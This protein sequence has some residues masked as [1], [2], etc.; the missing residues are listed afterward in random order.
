VFL[1]D[2]GCPTGYRPD[3]KPSDPYWLH[4]AGEAKAYSF[5]EKVQQLAQLIVVG[6]VRDILPS[7]WITPDGHRPANPHIIHDLLIITPIRVEV[8][9][10]A[11]G[12]YALPDIYLAAPGG[13]IGDDCASYSGSGPRPSFRFG[14]RYLYFVSPFD[15]T[16]PNPVPAE[17][18]YRFFTPRYSYTVKPDGTLTIGPE[19][20]IMGHR[21]DDPPRTLTVDEALRE[22]AALLATPAA[23]PTR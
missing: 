10:V 21:V 13:R 11:K 8:E 4:V 12:T 23:T 22:I 19:Y 17:S 5:N 14:E 1:G 6:T 20:D 18:K 16:L 3:R 15:Y 7:R 2:A 9:R